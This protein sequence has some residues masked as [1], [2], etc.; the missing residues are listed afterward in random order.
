MDIFPIKLLCKIIL[1][2]EREKRKVV[3]EF[4]VD[5]IGCHCVT[6]CHL[7]SFSRRCRCSGRP[8]LAPSIL[9]RRGC[10][11]YQSVSKRALSALNPPG[12]TPQQLSIGTANLALTTFLCTYFRAR[13]HSV[14]TAPLFPLVLLVIPSSIR[15]QC[16]IPYLQQSTVLISFQALKNCPLNINALEPALTIH[17][18]YCIAALYTYLKVSHNLPHFLAT[19]SNRQLDDFQKTT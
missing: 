9:A 17:P 11:P 4:D 1:N 18:L 13:H 19:L 12:L 14:T 15:F 3:R 8:A 10:I 5:P 7:F 6:M 2:H 16:A